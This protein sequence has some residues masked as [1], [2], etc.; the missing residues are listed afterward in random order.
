MAS[1]DKRCRWG[2]ESVCRQTKCA[3]MN[4]GII[5][6]ETLKSEVITLSKK[7]PHISHLREMPWGLHV[8]PD[9]LLVEIHQNIRNLHAFCFLSTRNVNA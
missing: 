8:D 7:F 3:L 6:C 9:K 1:A 4:I 5:Y 2:D